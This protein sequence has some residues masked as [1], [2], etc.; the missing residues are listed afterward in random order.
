[1]KMNKIDY[2]KSMVEILKNG[3]LAEE[4]GCTYEELAQFCTE[5][6]DRLE[7]ASAKR[8]MQ[9]NKTQKANV[10]LKEQLLG[11]LNDTP[12]TASDL[13]KFVTNENGEGISVQ[14]ASSLLR[15]MA[16]EGVIL[17]K[18]VKIAKKGAQKG[19]YLKPE[20]PEVPETETETETENS[21]G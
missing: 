4:C 5:E 10:S 2:F 16:L 15:Q 9:M 1:M 19:Y 18:D 3:E 12:Q 13:A 11:L 6:I 7:A 17:V 8:K 20:E 14:K 21:E